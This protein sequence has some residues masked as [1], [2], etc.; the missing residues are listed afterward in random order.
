MQIDIDDLWVVV[1][2]IAGHIMETYI[3]RCENKPNERDL[4]NYWYKHIRPDQYE[5]D[6]YGIVVTSLKDEKIIEL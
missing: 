6:I 3:F 2:D 5:M 4:K 1:F